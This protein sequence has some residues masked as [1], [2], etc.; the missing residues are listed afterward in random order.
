MNRISTTYNAAEKANFV[1]ALNRS[2]DKDLATQIDNQE[3]ALQSEVGV[4][5]MIIPT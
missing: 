4:W 2:K 1:N 3:G 5:E